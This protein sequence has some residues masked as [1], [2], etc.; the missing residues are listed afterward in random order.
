MRL[1]RIIAL[2][3]C[4]LGTQA[5][6]ANHKPPTSRDVYNALR[7]IDFFSF[8]GIGYAGV[9]PPGQG[10][11]D[12]LMRRKDS[13]DLFLRLLHDER[14]TDAAKLYALVGIRGSLSPRFE[15]EVAPFASNP[16]SVQV[17]WGC[18]IGHQKMSAIVEQILKDNYHVW[19]DVFSPPDPPADECIE[20][21]RGWHDKLVPPKAKS[22]PVPAR[23]SLILIPGKSPGDMQLS[24]CAALCLAAVSLSSLAAAQS[25]SMTLK[26]WQALYDKAG[27]AF[28]RKDD[29]WL[30][31][32]IAS[33]Y[34][35]YHPDGKLQPPPDFKAM[36]AETKTI[37]ASFK[38]L[39]VQVKGNT[40][41]VKD[42]ESLNV[43]LNAGPDGNTH[44]VA[45]IT[46]SRDK[47]AERKGKWLLVET[48]DLKTSETVD[49]KVVK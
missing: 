15:A 24:K 48:R 35:E 22:R 32:F 4:I 26:Q 38:V 16:K 49:G 39:S 6:L 27:K 10:L 3:L 14:A 11:F 8:G 18:C 33:D 37:R 42:T 23:I 28:E 21:A 17:M 41:L 2:A 20:S 19:L 34:K 40:I 7:D 12:I 47:W 5:A 9:M 44:V 36:F 31:G 43:T 25:K 45:Q 46:T 13:G 29:K 1:S 30:L